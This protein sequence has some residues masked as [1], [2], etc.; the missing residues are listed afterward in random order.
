MGWKWLAGAALGALLSGGAAQAAE[1]PDRARIIATAE[2]HVGEHLRTD[3]SG[4]VLQVLGE[5][6][7]AFEPR[8]APTGSFAIWLATRHVRRPEPGDLAFF[9]DTTDRNRNGRVDDP[10]THVAIVEAV[11]GNEVTMIE[12]GNHGITRLRLN[13]RW[14]HS[15]R[16]NSILRVP[17]ANDPPG[18]QYLSGEL[19]SGFGEVRPPAELAERAPR[20]RRHRG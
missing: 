20:R 9:H 1:A 2:K 12:H 10:W 15:H 8:E 14:R 18:V 5:A 19:L 4:F 6:G 3:C 16:L 17:R 11:T 13:L 7:V